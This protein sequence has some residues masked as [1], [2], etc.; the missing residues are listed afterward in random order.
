MWVISAVGVLFGSALVGSV[1]VYGEG[2]A[3]VS[4][5]VDLGGLGYAS[6]VWGTNM[7]AWVVG[8]RACAARDGFKAL[9]WNMLR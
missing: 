8:R 3:Y 6:A 5:D 7:G 9:H 2:E 4:G 1:G